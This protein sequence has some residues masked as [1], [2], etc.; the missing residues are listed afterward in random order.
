MTSIKKGIIKH[1]TVHLG[2]D[3]FK[4]RYNFNS[5]CCNSRIATV[6]FERILSTFVKKF[7][8]P[9]KKIFLH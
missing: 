7:V 1:D 4:K 5:R 9:K 3:I 2:V 8:L 6:K